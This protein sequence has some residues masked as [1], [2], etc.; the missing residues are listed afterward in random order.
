M[1]GDGKHP[2]MDEL[3]EKKLAPFLTQTSLNFWAK[4][5]WYFQQGLY[6][7]VRCAAKRAGLCSVRRRG[8][9]QRKPTWGAAGG[10]CAPG[11]A[12]TQSRVHERREVQA[13]RLKPRGSFARA[14]LP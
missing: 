3:F 4:R 7:Q 1:F 11:P 13:V 12:H 8:Q 10:A 9:Q 6:Y 5:L 2:R 14:E